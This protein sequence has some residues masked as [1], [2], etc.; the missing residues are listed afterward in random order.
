VSASTAGQTEAILDEVSAGG[1]AEYFRCTKDE[2]ERAFLHRYS[3]GNAVNRYKI[4]KAKE[5]GGTMPLDVALRRN[6]EDWWAPLP[7]DIADKIAVPLHC[8][9][10]LCHVFHLDFV[11]KKGVDV[12]ALKTRMLGYLQGRGAQYPAEHN[13]GHVYEAKPAQVAFYRKLDPTNAFNPGIGKTTKLR[14]WRLANER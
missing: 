12:E 4:M 9:H 6:D 2:G 10:F 3:A 11:I 14:N 7:A 13:V 5:V 1:Q 8:A